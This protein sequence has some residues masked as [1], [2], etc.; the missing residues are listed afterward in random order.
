MPVNGEYYDWEDIT[1][2]LPNGPLIDI[3][4]VE[5]KATKDI[6]EV[7]GQGAAPRGFGDGNIKFDGK[8][9]LLREE[10]ARFLLWCVASGKSPLKVK[11]T[12]SVAYMNDD[13][14]LSIDQLLNC[15]ITE[16][17]KAAKQGD[18]KMLVELPIKYLD[19]TDNGVS[20]TSGLNLW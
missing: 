13:Q 19:Q 12:V 16:I 10:Y 11:F 5:Y 17:G 20:L 2:L 8:I 6:E 4:S 15:K 14:G 1:V 3:D 18:K 9:V 7:Y